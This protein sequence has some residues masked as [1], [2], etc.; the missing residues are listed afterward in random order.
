MFRIQDIYMTGPSILH[1]FSRFRPSYCTAVLRWTSLVFNYG[2][3]LYF[4]EILIYH[5]HYHFDICSTVFAAF[6][7]S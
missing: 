3:Q 2:L 1:F 7:R 5:T 4:L 6:V